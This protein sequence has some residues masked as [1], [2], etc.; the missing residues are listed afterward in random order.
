M[1]PVVG[2]VEG[3]HGS[4]AELV[5]E[6]RT[7]REAR[8]GRTSRTRHGDILGVVRLGQNTLV[9]GQ[10]GRVTAR[11]GMVGEIERDAETLLRTEP[12]GIGKIDRRTDVGDRLAEPIVAARVIFRPPHAAERVG[13]GARLS[14]VKGALGN[15]VHIPADGVGIHVGRRCLGDLNGFNIVERGLLKLERAPSVRRLRTRHPVAVHR[16]GIEGTVDPADLYRADISPD[17]NRRDP[18]QLLEKIADVA[19]RHVA[20]AIGRH[21]V[22]HVERFAL[23]GDRGRT[24]FARPRHRKRSQPVDAR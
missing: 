24:A 15:D 13:K 11:L 14:T 2:G 19:V 3:K 16:H 23:L 1:E 20:E 6:L 9:G 4:L 18:R 8:A 17:V 12:V 7:G 10:G 21:D 5:F 22:F